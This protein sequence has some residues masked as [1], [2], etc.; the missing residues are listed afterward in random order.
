MWTLRG[1]D[2]LPQ[3]IPDRLAWIAAWLYLDSTRSVS[4]VRDHYSSLPLGPVGLGEEPVGLPGDIDEGTATQVRFLNP[5]GD[6]T[7]DWRTVTHRRKRR[8][9][10]RG[11]EAAEQQPRGPTHDP[12]E[13]PHRG[14]HRGDSQDADEPP[15]GT[16]DPLHGEFE[17]DMEVL[18]LWG[19]DSAMSVFRQRL[20]FTI[21]DQSARAALRDLK[22]IQQPDG[23]IR[24]DLTLVK[25]RWNE[26]TTWLQKGRARY[27]WYFRRHVPYLERVGRGV[28]RPERQRREAAHG[29][30]DPPEGRSTPEATL[31]LNCCSY[32][33]SG[34][35]KK[36]YEIQH[37]TQLVKPDVLALQETLL[38]ATHWDLR[39]PGYNVYSS[40]GDTAQSTRGVSICVRSTYQSVPIGKNS[41]YWTFV[42]VLGGDLQAPIILGS[43]YVPN[44]RDRR[45]VLDSLPEMV[46]SIRDTAPAIP[47]L[48]MGD[49]NTV[50][51][52]LQLEMMH[53][54]Q[55]LV[56][57]RN[58][59][60]LPTCSRQN[61]RCIDHFVG[62]ATLVAARPPQ[63]LSDWDL[64]D[65]YPIQLQLSG[66]RQVTDQDESQTL[67]TQT[68]RLRVLPEH[69][70]EI[71]SFNGWEILR[72]QFQEEFAASD[73]QETLNACALEWQN[74][75]HKVAKEHNLVPSSSGPKPQR[76]PRT[77]A[78][79]INR[80]R[81][82][83]A[84]LASLRQSEQATAQEIEDLETEYRERRKRAKALIRKVKKKAWHKQISNSL[85]W[86]THKPR[87]FWQWAK[88]VGRWQGSVKTGGIQPVYDT[89]GETLL[90]EVHDIARRWHDHF[91]YLASEGN[92]HSQDTDH[93]TFLD[94]VDSRK[95]EI[96]ELNSDIGRDEVWLALKKAKN[97]KAPGIDGVP[98][99]F[100]KSA[101]VEEK[102][103]RAFQDGPPSDEVEPDCPMSDCITLLVNKAFSLGA[104]AESWWNSTVVPIPKKGDLADVN[105][106]RGISLMPTILKVLTIVLS[107][108][109][110]T[111]GDSKELFCP[112]QAGFRRLEECTTQAACVLEILQRRK[113]ARNRTFATFIDFKKAYDMVPHG[114]LFAKLSQM[115]IRGRCLQFLQGLYAH[116][117]IQVRV[118]AGSNAHYSEPFPL[119]RGLRQ[120]CPLSPVLFNFFI[121]DL[122]D[123][124]PTG[125][126]TFGVTVPYG[127]RP[128]RCDYRVNGALFADD[129]VGFSDSIA[130]VKGFC[131]HVEDWC[132]AN[133]MEV[134]IAKCG[135]LEVP[136]HGHPAVLLDEDNPL[137]N[138]LTIG[139]ERVPIVT[140]YHYLGLDM[141]ASLDV[142]TMV[143]SRFSIGAKR[144]S[145]LQ[146]F[147]TNSMIPLNI[148]KRVMDAVVLPTLLY[149]AEIYGM[150]RR[151]TDRMQTLVNRC[152]R[153]ILGL[154]KFPLSKIPS[155]GLW[156][157]C[158]AHPICALAA[159]RRARAFL[160]SFKLKSQISF[161][162][163]N[164]LRARRWTWVTGCNRWF[165]THALKWLLPN[166]ADG[167]SEL[168]SFQ[169]PKLVRAAILEAVR[170]REE[171]IRLRGYRETAELNQRYIRCNFINLMRA[172]VKCDPLQVHALRWL[173][174]FRL[175]AV[176]F[177]F[178]QQVVEGHTGGVPNRCPFCTDVSRTNEVEHLVFDCAR[179]QG[180]RDK[181]IDGIVREAEAL[182]GKHYGRIN[183]DLTQ[184]QFCLQ[185]LLGG[186]FEDI[187]MKGWAPP[188]LVVSGDHSGDTPDEEASSTTGED[189]DSSAS[190]SS[191]E[192]EELNGDV[193]SPNDDR[194][195]SCLAFQVGSFLFEV[196][197]L[198]AQI[199][200]ACN[201]PSVTAAGQSPNG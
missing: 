28:S 134:G 68:P 61:G 3:H 139:G 6:Q 135:I 67:M 123:H 91:G 71:A 76:V 92:G 2:I 27:G 5:S 78:R 171:Q 122:M 95:P 83:H 166:D 148:K 173:I 140:S 33:I 165:R 100:I 125:D 86:L 29:S 24:F 164:P 142:A 101:L 113:I 16:E 82:T 128:Y 53:W 54:P 186:S 152:Y 190:S 60:D 4:S 104:T 18:C 178:P 193:L 74:T 159:S 98:M 170:A 145:V 130:T 147:L 73:S 189:D 112:A 120:G 194:Q 79:A 183:R 12:E 191:S 155:V 66:L 56:L 10:T 108:R 88:R 99:D 129:C 96:Q 162:V 111:V 163:R 22:R 141:V 107:N 188:L 1:L 34:V 184:N 195:T 146:P 69:R 48:L 149:G 157:E 200:Q 13:V 158:G 17:G 94:P 41:P 7:S 180:L 103:L 20:R 153:S 177:E 174:R 57:L 59:G 44:V 192:D 172:K 199:L 117:S 118:G 15:R 127:G 21:R 182:Y 156:T 72:T 39:I 81:R 42:K 80:R 198:R 102:A 58:E 93:W 187:C 31:S 150:N 77:V 36:R 185:M 87:R 110:N 197:C 175:Q 126:H 90:T 201:G 167:V 161:M 64:S 143:E 14:L 97:N 85:L 136:A 51:E 89:D 181:W 114:A 52:T 169:E 115:G 46:Q 137:R 55:G 26:Y 45:T 132:D 154:N 121:N 37:F 179:W 133:E 106:H 23:N 70:E 19:E 32:N 49:F 160:K 50:P 38:T 151:L 63:V 176:N 124:T 105:N 62:D 75:C 119:L 30:Q 116:S 43:I 35:D 144:T 47:I 11:S 40:L 168:G 138:D 131:R 25:S 196:M 109:L 8:R 65:H 84:K 9:I